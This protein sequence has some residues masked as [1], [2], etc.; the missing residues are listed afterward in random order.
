MG[1]A[2]RE[3]DRLRLV[4]ATTRNPELRAELMHLVKDPFMPFQPSRSL[5]DDVA[6][7]D[8]CSP[9][10][11]PALAPS[12]L[13][14]THHAR[15]RRE[16]WAADRTAAEPLGG[17]LSDVLAH[18][19]GSAGAGLELL[20]AMRAHATALRMILEAQARGVVHLPEGL[21]D[22]VTTAAR[23]T[24]GFLSGP[25]RASRA[26]RDGAARIPS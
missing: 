16:R 19:L 1:W 12:T 20:T 24:P 2:P 22:A 5:L 21:A 15:L 18:V 13:C 10:A 11:A 8:H 7:C 6:A 9:G 14:S 17:E 23:Q 3:A 26:E 4:L 25:P